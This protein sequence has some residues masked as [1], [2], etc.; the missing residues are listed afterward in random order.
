MAS[1]CRTQP[2]D[3]GR[4]TAVSFDPAPAPEGD[5]SLQVQVRAPVLV[6]PH[7]HPPT[8]LPGTVWDDHCPAESVPHRL[9]RGPG[10]ADSCARAQR[11]YGVQSPG[12]DASRRDPA[13]PRVGGLGSRPAVPRHSGSAVGPG[14]ATND[15]GTAAVVDYPLGDVPSIVRPPGRLNEGQT[16]LTNGMNVGGRAGTPSAP[17]DL[18]PGAHLYNLLAG[19][20]LR[21]QIVNCATVRYFRLPHHQPRGG[22][23]GANRR[24]E[25]YSTTRLSKA[26]PGGLNKVHPVRSYFRRPVAR[27][28]SRP[29]L[30]GP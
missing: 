10:A 14:G 15:D 2:T 24:W 26:A 23:G 4:R 3:R 22:G 9:G 13:L 1:S 7:H 6:P 11:H 21:L 27:T 18:A 20:G 29:S 8:G 28:S 5:L 30:P 16:V 19:Q 25:V 17:G 12:S